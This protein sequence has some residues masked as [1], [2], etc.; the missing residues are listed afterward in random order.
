MSKIKI[1]DESGD[2]KYFTIIPNYVYNHSTIW[3]REVYCQ[4]K[5]IAGE[6]G[7]CWIARKNLAKQCGIS[8][9]RLDASIK[10]LLEHKW[11]ELIGKKKVTTKGGLQEVNEY[12][13]CDLWQT[14]NQF[15]QDKGVAPKTPPLPKGA[16]DMRGGVR[17]TFWGGVAH[18]SHKEEP[19]EEEPLEEDIDIISNDIIPATTSVANQ[20]I[21]DVLNSFKGINPT[22]NFGNKTQRK[23]AADL[24]KQF[25]LEKVMATI[26]YYKTIRGDK[27]SPVIT[28][29]YQLKEKMGQLIAYYNKSQTPQKGGM[30]II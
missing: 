6:Q 27:F 4:M 2:R 20:G 19:I 13:I 23:A 22:I 26:D 25:G 8:D 3:D 28:T 18:G 16:N 7:T 11:I 14:N 21:T 30:T 10:Y 9:R 1:N 29:P 5:R 12:T 15:Y 17:T 24:V